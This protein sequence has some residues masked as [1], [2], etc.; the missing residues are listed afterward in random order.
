MRSA[1]GIWVDVAGDRIWIIRVGAWKW[2]RMGM[3]GAPVAVF[4]S[5]GGQGRHAG[6]G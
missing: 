6:C 4:D 1:V 5:H 3:G 2:I